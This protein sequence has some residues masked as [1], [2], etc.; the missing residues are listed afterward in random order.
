MPPWDLC[1]KKEEAE[2]ELQRGGGG[3]RV[4]GLEEGWLLT[5]QCVGRQCVGRQRKCGAAALMARLASTGVQMVSAS[6]CWLPHSPP[7]SCLL[8]FFKNKKKPVR[9]HQPPRR[10]PPVSD[11]SSFVS[12]GIP[13][14]CPTPP[15]TIL[16]RRTK[17]DLWTATHRTGTVQVT[18]RRGCSTGRG[19]AAGVLGV[20]G[21]CPVPSG[22]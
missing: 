9:Q 20:H 4:Q 13:R 21:T 5:C 2:V 18:A 15:R 14:R 12:E 19:V 1:A 11:A 10:R 7:A 22:T 6:S 3:K 16:R 17:R 8:P